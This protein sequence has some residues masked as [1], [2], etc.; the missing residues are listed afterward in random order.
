[1]HRYIKGDVL[2]GD[3]TTGHVK[4][5]DGNLP[6]AILLRTAR[7]EWSRWHNIA[8]AEDGGC[9]VWSVRCDRHFVVTLCDPDNLQCNFCGPRPAEPRSA[10]ELAAMRWREPA[11]A[12]G[13]AIM[14]TKPLPFTRE[15]IAPTEQPVAT[16]SMELTCNSLT[17]DDMRKAI[18]AIRAEAA[19][20]PVRKVYWDPAR[21]RVPAPPAHVHLRELAI[22]HPRAANGEGSLSHCQR[23]HEELPHSVVVAI[24]SGTL[25]CPS[26][27][28]HAGRCEHCH[29]LL[30][31]RWDSQH[32]RVVLR[33]QD[34]EGVDE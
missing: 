16:S 9:A 15:D 34:C 13:G 33:C 24:A 5:C 3:G 30:T 27:G 7:E 11:L 25:D 26:C 22:D 17:T 18:A 14:A 12:N 23:C 28:W 29:G 31:K 10:E 21:M 20:P 2:T 6:G 32:G 4:Y 19:A 8:V 1:M